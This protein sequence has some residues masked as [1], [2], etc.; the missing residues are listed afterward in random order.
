MTTRIPEETRQSL[1]R[2]IQLEEL[3][4][5]LKLTA[6]GKSPG[7]DGV[8]VEFFKLYW[9]LVKEDYLQMIKSSLV[10]GRF[11]PSMIAGVLTQSCFFTREDHG[12]S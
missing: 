6:S 9:N 1:S 4:A 2:P 12:K 10:N 8:V 5:A 11:P 3:K 7:S